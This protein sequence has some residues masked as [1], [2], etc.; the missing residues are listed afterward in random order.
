[1]DYLNEENGEPRLEEEVD[2]DAEGV[3][4]GEAEAD[5]ETSDSSGSGYC[6]AYL[7]DM[8][9]DHPRPVCVG[10]NERYATASFGF[11]LEAGR[12]VFLDRR[13]DPSQS[14]WLFDMRTQK[15]EGVP[16]PCL[17]PDGDVQ[18]ESELAG[19]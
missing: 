3:E 6:A 12:M 19:A 17:P 9:P 18:W 4:E 15:L 8:P 5:Q 14:I 10:E 11:G 2:A 16:V 13:Q 1:M 7:P